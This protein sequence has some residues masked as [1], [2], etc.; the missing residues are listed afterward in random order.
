MT[1]GVYEGVNVR[2]GVF[3]AGRK[4]VGDGVI[5]A[6]TVGVS[7]GVGVFVAVPVRIGGVKLI[8]GIPSVPVAVGE[9][10]TSNA[11]G[12]GVAVLESG[13]RINA[14]QPMQ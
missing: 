1:V 6:V 14:S 9:I 8:V 4:F 2:V 7:V 10:V 12:V 11:V 13:A 5:V 3:D